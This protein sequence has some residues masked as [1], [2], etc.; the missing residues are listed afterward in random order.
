MHTTLDVLFF[1]TTNVDKSLVLKILSGFALIKRGTE[2]RSF[3][4]N[5]P[6]IAE[7]YKLKF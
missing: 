1:S 5:L 6:L 3:V 4:L 7:A 2:I